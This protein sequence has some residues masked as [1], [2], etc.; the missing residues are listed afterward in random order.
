MIYPSTPFRLL[1]LF[2]YWNIINYFYSSKY[3]IGEDWNGVLKEMIPVFI[4]ADDTL[5]YNLAILQL[6][7]KINDS[8]AFFF[9]PQLFKY[10]G[11]NFTP[12]S[13]MI[14]D[15]K[16]VVTKL[17]SDS[18]AHRDD[19]KAGD[20]ILQMDG[21]SVKQILRENWKY[22]P[23]S[24]R[25]TKLRG[26][27]ILFMLSPLDSSKILFE[28]D[29]IKRSG[30][31]HWYAHPKF[32]MSTSSLQVNEINIPWKIIN[33]SILYINPIQIDK[34]KLK[35]FL[36]HLNDYKGLIV[37]LRYYNKEI[38]VDAISRAIH[39][40]R[41]KFVKFL[42][43]VKHSPGKFAFF[44]TPFDETGHK[45]K[46]YYKGKTVLLFNETTQSVGELSCMMLLSADNVISIGSQT[47]G[48]DGSAVPIVLPGDY[49]TR[50]SEMGVY[51]PNE[52]PTQ[53]VG[54]QPEIF[55]QPTILGISRREDEVLESAIDYLK[56][57][58]DIRSKDNKNNKHTV[59]SE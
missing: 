5:F 39:R 9:T 1:A 45:N 6:S 30:I 54:I 56:E 57:I 36:K 49:V 52:S 44:N 41:I 7:A 12:F 4:N 24:N 27:K 26:A 17:S 33:D 53:Q 46:H 31:I 40:K 2:R 55:V 29:G 28:R 42:A 47:A 14:I 38:G 18:L 48:A 10:F 15:N 58:K 34:K 3:L 11:H 21:K 25:P 16:A 37:D 32:L 8:H 59:L 13:V 23:A 35:K 19:I 50:F 20:A 51:Y 22:L 43:L